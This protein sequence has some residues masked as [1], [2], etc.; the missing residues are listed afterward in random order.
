MTNRIC[1]CSFGNGSANR[2]K[3]GLRLSLCIRWIRC[4]GALPR[5]R[6]STWCCRTST[7]R[8]W[9]DL[10]GLERL[11]CQS[12]R[13]SRHG[14]G[15]RRLPQHPRSDEPR[16]FDFPGPSRSTLGSRNER[17]TRPC[18]TSA[19]TGER[20]GLP[21]EHALLRM[22]VNSGI[23]PEKLIPMMRAPPSRPPA[24]RPKPRSSSILLRGF[25][26]KGRS[27]AGCR[28]AGDQFHF[29]PHRFRSSHPKRCRRRSSSATASLQC[30][31]GWSLE[32]A[33]RDLFCRPRCPAPASLPKR[34]LTT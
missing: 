8:G 16:A 31:A 34:P 25:E 5:L 14:V 33:V 26:S 11:G 12:A 15:I 19:P 4:A 22:F 20:P 32:R 21:E 7:C 3:S 6:M 23:V 17:S 9:M 1:L 2:S 13:Q 27:A 29:G 18:S 10:S 28:A 30:S 24:N